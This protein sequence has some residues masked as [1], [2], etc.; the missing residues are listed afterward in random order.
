MEKTADLIAECAHLL[1][2]S[3]QSLVPVGPLTERFPE[4]SVEQ[5]YQ[6]Q[7]RN[8]ERRTDRGDTVVGHKVGLTSKPMQRMLGVP[9]PDFGHLFQSMYYE[10]GTVVDYPL[11]QPKVEPE[12][13]FILKHD[14]DSVKTTVRD[15]LQA[16]EYVVP[17]I[18]VIDSRVAD[19]KIKLPDTV[20]DNA[21]SGC[22]VLGD[23]YTSIDKVN[24]G[25]IGGV[26]KM[27][28]SVVQTGAGAAVLGHP[29]VSVAWLANKLNSLGTKLKAG[30]VVLSGAVSAAVT[31]H[32][33]D[34]VSVSFGRLGTVSAT[35]ADNESKT[36][37]R[38]Q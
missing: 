35:R 36:G 26:M 15:V 18:E 20:A 2:K 4:L 11:I 33:G 28:G 10:S 34:S 16:T 29:A 6:V 38:A 1:D 17:A 8:V 23:L 12:L 9:E 30:D 32:P 31:F 27:N 5:A 14:L 22:F 19:W 21:S 7:M 3:E 37:A 25:T 13:A 24:L